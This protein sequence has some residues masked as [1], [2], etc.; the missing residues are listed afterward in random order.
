MAKDK[1]T[2][3]HLMKL[4][5]EERTNELRTEG[6]AAVQAI[7]REIMELQRQSTVITYLLNKY[8]GMTEPIITTFPMP[9]GKPVGAA[10]DTQRSRQDRTALV[11][12]TALELAKAGNLEI[13]TNDVLDALHRKGITLDVKRPTSMIGTVLKAMPEFKRLEM[14]RFQYV[15]EKETKGPF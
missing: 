10:P 5:I 8:T 14:N 4:A 15:G 6:I 12:Q 1:D 7:Q 9:A 11:K 3:K 13:S 2:F